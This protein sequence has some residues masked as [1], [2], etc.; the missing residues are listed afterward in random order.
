MEQ[1]VFLLYGIIPSILLYG[2]IPLIFA[3]TLHEAAHAFVAKKLGDN[4]SYLLGRVT[5]NPIKHIDPI[6]TLLVPAITIITTGFIFGWAKPVPVKF[7]NLRK[8]KEDSV[9]VAA[10]G[11]FANLFMALIWAFIFLAVKEYPSELSPHIQLMAKLGVSF[12]V[13]FMILNLLPI[14]PLDGG[15]ILAGLLPHKWSFEYSKTEP[16][17][18]WIILGLLVLGVLTPILGTGVKFAMSLLT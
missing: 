4:T 11:P 17:G 18:M 8:P 10:A 7:G 1:L 9:Y 5:L 13:A 2:I 14:L 16:Y 15:R 12:N 3:I 6:G